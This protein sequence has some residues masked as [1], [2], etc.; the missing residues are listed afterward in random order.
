MELL[1]V[2][3]VLGI[4]AS[5]AVPGYQRAILRTRA[6]EARSNLQ[7]IYDA[8]RQY[9]MKN[10]AYWTGSTDEAVINSAL[11]L[12]LEKND[13]DYTVMNAATLGQAVYLGG[14]AITFRIDRNGNQ[15]CLGTGCGE[16]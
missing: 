10:G 9:M 12:D 3:V 2:I 6:Q 16:L 13:W 5:I 11:H 7:A 8:Q 1:L 15:T 14:L 4:L